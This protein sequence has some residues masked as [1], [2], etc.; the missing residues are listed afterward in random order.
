MGHQVQHI[1]AQTP[2]LLSDAQCTEYIADF[3]YPFAQHN[4]TKHNAVQHNTTQN[5]SITTT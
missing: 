1:T 3:C 2:D 5:N 4:T